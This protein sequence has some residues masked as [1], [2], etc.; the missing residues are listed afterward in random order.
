MVRSPHAGQ[1]GKHD[2]PVAAVDQPIV[3][4]VGNHQQVVSLG[5]LRDGQQVRLVQDRAGGIVGIA[6]H[7]HLGALRDR[8]LDLRGRDLELVLDPGRDGHRHAAGQCDG[9]REA[10]K[11]RLRNDDLVPGIQ[12]CVEGQGGR[13]ADPDRDQNLPARIVFGAVVEL[14]KMRQDGLPQLQDAGVV[15]VGRAAAPQGGDAGFQDGFGG[16]K[17]R[18][19]DAE[20]DDI[21]QRV[22]NLEEPAN[23]RRRQRRSPGT[24]AARTNAAVERC[25]LVLHEGPRFAPTSVSAAIQTIGSGTRACQSVVL[26]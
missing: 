17:V 22:G 19:A 23:G 14:P 18:F 4:F 13:L 16:D 2:V 6:Q 7:Q 3:D 15:R 25:A 5:H 26:S 11:A 20:A 12:Q 24:D 21:V 1:A 9:G 8:L 10:D